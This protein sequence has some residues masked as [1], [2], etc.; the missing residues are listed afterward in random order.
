MKMKNQPNSIRW[1]EAEKVLAA[2]KYRFDR[3]NGSHR[4]YIGENGGR[5]TLP[6][7]NPMRKVYVDAVLEK[8]GE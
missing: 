5:L 4:Q 2:Y 7:K 8:I 3:Q 1:E 6:A